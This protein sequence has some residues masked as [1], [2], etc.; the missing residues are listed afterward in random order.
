[1]KIKA[2]ELDGQWVYMQVDDSMKMEQSTPQ[3]V[4]RGGGFERKGAGEEAARQVVSSLHGVVK[5]VATTTLSALRDAIGA[6]VDKVTLE[7]GVTL[8]GEAGIPFVSS[9]KAEGT[10]KVSVECSFPQRRE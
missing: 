2:I 7:F 5:A 9:G 10:I 8:G 4:M 3:T 6:N 1:M